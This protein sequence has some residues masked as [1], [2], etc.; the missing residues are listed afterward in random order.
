MVQ[1]FWGRGGG[2]A[3]QAAG[4]HTGAAA[5]ATASDPGCQALYARQDGGLV[6]FA[7]VKTA[8]AT[9]RDGELHSNGR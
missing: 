5:G 8:A 7:V 6:A 1:L 4:S 3:Q 2:D 9:K